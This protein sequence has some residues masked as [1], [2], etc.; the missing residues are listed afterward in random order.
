MIFCREGDCHFDGTGLELSAELAVII[1]HFL[2]VYEEDAGA[3]MAKAL[4]ES[5]LRTAMDIK[6][7][8][9]KKR[10]GKDKD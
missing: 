2:L 9:E 5:V 3:D 1:A 8:K 10:N 6:E 4:F 7:E